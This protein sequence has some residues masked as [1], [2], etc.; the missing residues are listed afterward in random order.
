MG[1]VGERA[2]YLLVKALVGVAIFERT[3]RSNVRTYLDVGEGGGGEVGRKGRFAAIPSCVEGGEMVADEL[4]EAGDLKGIVVAAHESDAGYL[5]L[6]GGYHAEESLVGEVFAYVVGEVDAMAA[7]TTV[8]ATRKV[9]GKGYLV[10]ELL[11]N[12]VVVDVFESARVKRG[13]HIAIGGH[14]IEK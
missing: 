8:G 2:V 9:D 1:D 11:K 10:G 3:A 4:G 14:E 12:D 7:R 6:I 5:A 13:A